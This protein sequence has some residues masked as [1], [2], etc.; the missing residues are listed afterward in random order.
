MQR[1]DFFK[2][3]ALGAGALALGSFASAG[4]LK[5]AKGE[6]APKGA[7]T[8]YIECRLMGTHKD[9]F[10]RQMNRLAN[11]LK[12]KRGFLSFSLKNMVGD[13]TMVKNYPSE[14]KGVLKTAYIDAA[15]QDTLPLFYSL[16][17]RFESYKDLMESKAHQEFAK[18]IK[19]YGS[20]SKNYHKGVYVTVS[21]GDRKR[22]YTS[23]KEIVEFLK[24]QKDKPIDD[25]VT[26]NN[27][28]AIYTKDREVFNKKSTA[29]LKIA[30]DTFRPAKGDFDYK[31]Q[32]PEGQPGSYQNNHYRKA[33]TTEILQS[34]FSEGG[35]THYLFHGTWE[36][37]W[38]HENSHIDIRFRQAVMNLFPYIV[39]GPIEPFYKTLIL[40]NS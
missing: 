31:A 8:L 12:T 13:S 9:K 5:P 25:L 20:I 26:V 30:Q 32:F 35:K 34:A 4:R 27:H 10:I 21:A 2:N 36:S 3:M 39:D 6:K 19:E 23:H 28:V 24:H 22:I 33:V 16:F 14:L 38:D 1:R 7:V 40:R 15:K 29:L 37:V 11:R 17:I 18:I